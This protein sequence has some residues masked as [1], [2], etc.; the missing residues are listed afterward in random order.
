MISDNAMTFSA[1]ANTIQSLIR[2]TTVQDMLLNGDSYLNGHP[3]S[4]DGG[5]D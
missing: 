5:R 1:A 3:G 2:S 4:A